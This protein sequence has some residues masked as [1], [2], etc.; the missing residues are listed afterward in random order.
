M[1]VTHSQQQQHGIFAETGLVYKYLFCSD[2]NMLF[3]YS[4][5]LSNNFIIISPNCEM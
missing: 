4:L 3:K 5:A 2:L 1:H